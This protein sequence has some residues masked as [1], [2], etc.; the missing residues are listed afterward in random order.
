M[1][2]HK[3]RKAVLA[4]STAFRNAMGQMLK[5]ALMMQVPGQNG[6]LG[7]VWE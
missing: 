5:T 1:Y 2:S 3:A 6:N 4:I 7:D